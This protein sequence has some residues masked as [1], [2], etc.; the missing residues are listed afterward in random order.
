MNPEERGYFEKK[1]NYTRYLK[2]VGDITDRYLEIQGDIN[3]LSSQIR[4]AA[5]GALS[6]DISPKNAKKEI[7]DLLDNI[8]QLKKE[9]K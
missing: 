3:V 4:N 5:R 2:P 9:G 1:S 7:S 6:G 8:K